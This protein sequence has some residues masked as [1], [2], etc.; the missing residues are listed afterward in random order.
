M[1]AHPLIENRVTRTAE[2]TLFARLL[3]THNYVISYN[4]KSVCSVAVLNSRYFTARESYVNKTPT[5]WHVSTNS[6]LFW[7]GGGDLRA[8]DGSFKLIIVCHRCCGEQTF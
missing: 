4:V 2:E 8:L 3:T 7:R 5:C 6:A 1:R